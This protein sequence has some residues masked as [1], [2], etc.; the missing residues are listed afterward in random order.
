MLPIVEGATLNEPLG[1]AFTEL[2]GCRVPIQ[3]AP[4]GSVSTPD[5]AVAVAEAGGVGSI[6]ALGL[7]VEFLDRLLGEITARTSGVLAVNFLTEDLDREA[8]AIAASRARLIDFF[9]VDPTEELI[10]AAHA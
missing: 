4:M 6:T 3:Q 8:L 9:W 10:A 1:T 2:V 5:L 7:P